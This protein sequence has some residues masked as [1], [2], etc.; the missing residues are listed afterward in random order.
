MNDGPILNP[1]S[2]KTQ[3]LSVSAVSP[4]ALDQA[5]RLLCEALDSPISP[6]RI[7]Q[8]T[9]YP[10]SVS[11]PLWPQAL[12]RA[13]SHIG[14]NLAAHGA[15]IA[16]LLDD[17]S[18]AAMPWLA[19]S[20]QGGGAVPAVV[21]EVHRGKARVQ[22]PGEDPRWMSRRE[23]VELLHLESDEETTVW[24]SAEP[25]APLDKLRSP[26]RNE[27]FDHK[28]LR[29]LRALLE[30]ER[31]DLWVV[32]IYSVAVGL[33]S[34][35][36]PIA[37]QSLVNTVAFGS[38]IQPLVVLTLAVLAAL[39]FSAVLNGF[40]VFVIE[41]IQRR[42]Y[43]RVAGDVAYRLLR[44]K[45]EAFDKHHGPELVNR[46]FDVVTVQKSA[47]LLLMDGLSLLMQT[48]L[49]MTLLA[50]YHPFLLAFD[51]FLIL[52][53]SAIIF[54]MGRGA[55]Q[56]AIK[57]S[58]AKYATAAWLE[59][60]AALTRTFK[61]GGSAQFAIERAD[62][63]TRDYLSYRQSHF[64]IFMRQVV[65]SLA[66]QAIASAAL[67]G[68]GGFLVIDRQLTLGQL[69]AAE[70]IV[71]VVVGGFSKFGKKFETFYDLL[72]AI[73]KLGAL[74]DLPLERLGGETLTPSGEPAQVC[75]RDVNYS[76][77][78]TTILRH[79]N[80]EIP[81][82]SAIGL[83][84]PTGGGKT[85]LADLLFGLRKPDGGVLTID[86]VDYRDLCLEELREQVA[87]T[88]DAD[89]FSG[90]VFE[91][92]SVGRPN[93]DSSRVREALTTV[94]LLDDVTDLPDG[95][96]TQLSMT[97]RPLSPGQTAQLALARAIAG[98]PRLLIL[99]GAFE[100]IDEPELRDQIASRIFDSNNPWT[101]L[102]ISS[103]PDL[104]RRCER[105]YLLDRGSLTE[106]AGHNSHNGG[107]A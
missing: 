14:L 6:D 60:M 23:L 87:V 12:T 3:F 86:D 48:V 105:L 35:V 25:A 1:G 15:G 29:R 75:F 65:G 9:S 64:R 40:R 16:D 91:N 47:A 4:S 22:L 69:V 62:R 24:V 43:A 74:I 32:V 93:V 99:D 95:I 54:V 92:V 83:T 94:G 11:P 26:S 33:L 101:L 84:G 56:S 82:G 42:I 107:E 96:Q 46:F 67:L 76:L 61:S 34:L 55:V 27:S 38:L 50:L 57:E 31:Q 89:I 104:L 53:I 97:G 51:L 73:D 80:W 66:L 102:C 58:K 17:R 71:T 10:E 36:V 13:G 21:L 45:A 49:G 79:T 30:A 78:G 52:A 5:L 70:L 98:H 2:V 63:L 20:N 85:A 59:E 100:K 44:V 103:Q 28:P 39:A 8:P 41:V 68:V 19:F 37:V 72:A 106:L 88:H 77:G 18:A 81:A 7:S 90:T